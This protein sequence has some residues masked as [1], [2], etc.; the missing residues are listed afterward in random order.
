MPL[1]DILN[2][3]GSILSS[4][5]YTGQ[6]AQLGLEDAGTMALLLK[7]LCL[8]EEGKFDIA[9]FGTAMK[10]YEKVRIPR[11]KEILDISKC[12]A[13]TQEQRYSQ[14]AVRRNARE[15]RIKRDVFFHE[16]VSYLIPGSTYHYR[17][18]VAELLKNEPVHL[19][20]VLE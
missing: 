10:L 1:F 15:E 11:T 18:A 4:V 13:K 6:G 12:W 16:T 19:P 17:E 14:V 5:P 3:S 8:D 9:N 20:A 7:E 2:D